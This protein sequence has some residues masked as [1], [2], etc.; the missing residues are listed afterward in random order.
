MA[1]EVGNYS[2]GVK[3][4]T[5]SL[6][7]GLGQSSEKSNSQAKDFLGQSSDLMGPVAEFL[8]NILSNDPS[9]V[10]QATAPQRRRVIDQ[11][12][13]AKKAIAEF[14]PRGG[15]QAAS[16]NK[17]EADKG[18]DLATLGADLRSKAVDSAADLSLRYAG[19]GASE[20]ANANQATAAALGGTQQQDA[21]RNS[22]WASLGS[23]LGQLLGFALLA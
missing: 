6:I 22:N 11:Y 14:T 10:A 8:K 19:L 23:G 13:T 1:A 20:H 2:S 12:A 3:P 7:A 18:G 16:L 5:D 15:G 9:A 21:T 4:S 17:L